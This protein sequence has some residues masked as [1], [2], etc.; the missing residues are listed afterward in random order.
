MRDKRQWTVTHYMDEYCGGVEFHNFD[1]HK[2]ARSF[3]EA[4]LKAGAG[5][6]DVFLENKLGNTL[7]LEWQREEARERRRKG[8]PPKSAYYSP[9]G[10]GYE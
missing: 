2:E 1:C 4:L 9:G 7:M 5:R 3:A 8:L 10:S 6:D